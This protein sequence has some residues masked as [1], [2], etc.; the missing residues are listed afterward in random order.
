MIEYK[1][2]YSFDINK[3]KFF[4]IKKN[5][6]GDIYQTCFYKSIFVDSICSY[7]QLLYKYLLFKLIE[8]IKRIK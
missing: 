2:N 3:P 6:S 8:R 4:I 1:K 7:P 5:K